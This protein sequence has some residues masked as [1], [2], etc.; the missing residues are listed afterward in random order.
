MSYFFK[1]AQKTKKFSLYEAVLSPTYA[2]FLFA[3]YATL[4][5]QITSSLF[6][7]DSGASELRKREWNLSPSRK[8]TNA[9]VF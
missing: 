4:S 3:R 9:P 6:F 8:V 2:D 1:I 5:N 7:R